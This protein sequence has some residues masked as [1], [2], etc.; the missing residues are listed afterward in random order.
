MKSAES[1][2][3]WLTNYLSNALELDPSDIDPETHLTEY[4]I[5]S[6]SAVGLSGDL[7]RWLG[8]ELKDSVA[9]EHPT[10]AALSQHACSQQE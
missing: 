5:D 10:I 1:I 3:Q 4:G 2:S 9:F 8:V 6:T 7:S